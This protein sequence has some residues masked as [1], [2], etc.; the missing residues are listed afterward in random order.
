MATVLGVGGVFFKSPDSERLARWYREALGLAVES[1]G[2]VGFLPSTMPPAGCTVWSVFPAATTHF[3]PS[4]KEFMFNFV[5]DDLEGVLTQAIAHGAT[6]VG[7][8]ETHPNGRF[9]WFLDPD[10]NKVELWEPR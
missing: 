10:Q 8:I 2:G 6:K 7:E 9:G 1:W 3:E 5:V 4:R